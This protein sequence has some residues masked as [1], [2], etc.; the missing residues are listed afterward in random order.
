MVEIMT[1][2]VRIS[3]CFYMTYWSSFIISTGIVKLF[4]YPAIQPITTPSFIHLHQ[5]QITRWSTNINIY[6]NRLICG[7]GISHITDWV[8]LIHSTLFQWSLLLLTD[9]RID[10]HWLIWSI[11]LIV[12][13]GHCGCCFW[14]LSG[15]DWSLDELHTLLNIGFWA[16]WLVWSIW[17]W[18]WM[19]HLV[20][21]PLSNLLHFIPI[22]FWSNCSNIS[23][24]LLVSL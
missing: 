10:L 8:W 2:I 24:S 11:S 9:C 22:L 7:I 20:V 18:Y 1:L 15:E 4:N 17:L 3:N 12:L 23:I 13:V 6:A 14:C 5:Y 19:S 16:F 21:Y